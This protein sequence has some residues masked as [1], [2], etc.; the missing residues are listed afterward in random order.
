MV[1]DRAG[2][3]K[4]LGSDSLVSGFARNGYSLGLARERAYSGCHWCAMPGREYTLNDCV[5]INLAAV[6]LAAWDDLSAAGS[7]TVERLWALFEQHL[8]RAVEVLAEGLDFHLAHM[9]E[10]FPELVMD[11]L[12][13]GT[14]E[15]GLDASNGGVEFVNLCVDGAGLATVADSFGA[16]E[17]RLETEGLLGWDDLQRAV[18]T[19]W[20]NPE[21]E[22]ARL[23]MRS[24]GRYGS[25]NSVADGYAVRV[26]RLF[27]D[28]VKEKPTPAGRNMIPGL[29]S[30]AAQIAMGADLGATPNGRRAGEAI[31]HGANP[32]PGFRKD[33]APSALANAI[34]AVQPGWGNSAPMQIEID[35]G[36]TQGPEAVDNLVALIR[37]HMELGGTQINMNVLDRAK[38]LEAH[39]DPTRYPDLVVRLTGFSVYF[40]SLSPDF[41]HMVVDR[42]L[43]AG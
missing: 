39:T 22:R 11:L 5:K 4:F 28:L 35:P 16:L 31:S 40:A 7:P 17:Q 29:F 30:W 32:D 2:V 12:C 9:H 43:D 23:L 37:T 6:F 42:L 36:L 34:A 33:G 3:P 10:V 15:Q 14:V 1:A 27:T 21:G 26:S 24:A 8:R 25:G 20:E 19:N 13:H 41:R 38:L 18:A